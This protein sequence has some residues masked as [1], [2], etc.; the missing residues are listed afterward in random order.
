[1]SGPHRRI[2]K[3]IAFLKAGNSIA[4]LPILCR[5]NLLQ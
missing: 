3:P 5:F 4:M 1:M 2:G